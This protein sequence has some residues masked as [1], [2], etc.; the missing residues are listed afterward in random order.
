MLNGENGQIMLFESD[1]A[2]AEKVSCLNHSGDE[3][4]LFLSALPEDI[5]G[6]ILQDK[7]ILQA[8]YDNLLSSKAWPRTVYAARL[9]DGTEIGYVAVKG[10][11]RPEP[12]L[13]IEVVPEYQRKGYG[14]QMLFLALQKIFCEMGASS[15]LYRTRP[16][17]LASIRLAE[18]FRAVLEEP[19]CEAESLLLRTY[20]IKDFIFAHEFCM[21]QKE[22]L[23]KDQKCGCFYCLKI[24]EPSQIEDWID[25][26][27][28]TA[29]CPYCDVDSVIGAYTGFPI[30]TEF[31][32]SMKN[33]WF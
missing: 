5:M 32:K 21:N 22:Q 26:T 14:E 6:H 16:D 11:E 29:I 2:F 8:L 31:L 9:A 4:E 24:F 10:Y 25:D 13:Q 30:T 3:A 17:N 23:L 19:S 20:H 18:R 27:S 7:S 1:A 12:E 33:Y 15:V 28:G